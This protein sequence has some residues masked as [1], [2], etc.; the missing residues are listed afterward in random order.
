[1]NVLGKMFLGLRLVEKLEKV[2]FDTR[3][4]ND[5]LGAKDD[6][7]ARSIDEAVN[8]TSIFEKPL[9]FQISIEK[10][11]DL[12]LNNFRGKKSAA[13][14]HFKNPSSYKLKSGEFKVIAIKLRAKASFYKIFEY[15]EARSG[16]MPNIAGLIALQ[17]ILPVILP[18]GSKVYGLDYANSLLIDADGFLCV[19]YME[20][21]DPDNKQSLFTNDYAMPQEA[22]L[23]KGDYFFFLQEK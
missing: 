12:S 22:Y 3:L 14:M 20:C 18:K 2:G 23:D 7:L 5:V 13:I 4:I 21:D 19:P 17:K 15:V 1:M 8:M 6:S 9:R 11:D 10:D 16:K